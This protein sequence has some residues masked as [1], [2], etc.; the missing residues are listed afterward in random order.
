MEAAH[1]AGAHKDHSFTN[2]DNS[3]G[4]TCNCREDTVSAVVWS[5]GPCP[6]QT[7]RTEALAGISS[8][9]WLSCCQAETARQHDAPP[10]TANTRPGSRYRLIDGRSRPSRRQRRVSGARSRAALV[11]SSMHSLPGRGSGDEHLPSLWEADR[12]RCGRR[13]LSPFSSSSSHCC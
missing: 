7:D 13:H 9:T 1:S 8:H 3:S 12:L 5:G 6:K 11:L 4:C 2:L 10:C